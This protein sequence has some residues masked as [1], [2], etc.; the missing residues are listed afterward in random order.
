MGMGVMVLTNDGYKELSKLKL[1]DKV[2]DRNGN[3]QDVLGLV[4]G[5]IE[6]VEDGNGKWNTELYEW[7][8]GIWIKGCS[9]V[10]VG[11]KNA[12]G[13]TLIT[14]TG[15]IIIWDDIEKKDKI[16]RDFTEIGYKEIHKT[17][18]LIASRL[19]LLNPLTRLSKV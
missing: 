4:Y 13:V 6:G 5:E 14:E 3:E 2:L 10:K 18:P 8:D 1:N 9:T 19:R 12:Y 16:V 7:R 17:Y 15:E 11:K